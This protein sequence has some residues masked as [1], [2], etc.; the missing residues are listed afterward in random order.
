V[1]RPF[2]TR[3]ACREISARPKE[4]VVTAA[5]TFERLIGAAREGSYPAW[6]EICD[7]L[8]PAVV[9]YLKLRGVV[10]PFS[11]AGD[12]FIELAKE[13]QAYDPASTSFR[14]L[15]FNAARLR[16]E[17][18]QRYS[19]QRFQSLHGVQGPGVSA[20]AD[21]S[22]AFDTL[23][24]EQ[25][26]VLG[27]RI[28]GGLDVEQTASVL[29]LHIDEVEAHES[30]GMTAMEVAL[31]RLGGSVGFGSP[32]ADLDPEPEGSPM[33]FLA[34]LSGDRPSDH[35]ILTCAAR[36]AEEATSLRENSSPSPAEAPVAGVGT[37]LKHRAVA[38]AATMATVMGL[39]GVALAV[40]GATP[41]DWYYGLDT[42]LEA[43]GIGAGGAEERL[44]EAAANRADPTQD[45]GAVTGHLRND[46][47]TATSVDETG[48]Q[49]A[50]AAV[51][52][53]QTGSEQS[54][55]VRD[56]VA[57]FLD[58]LANEEGLSGKE[59]AEIARTLNGKPSKANKPD[60]PGRPENPG[61]PDNPGR[62]STGRP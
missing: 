5:R 12:V 34:A 42:A 51:V 18:E 1:G 6:A 61:R 50:A 24:P 58:Y 8:A 29:N 52:A 43:I 45:S 9:S 26:D 44:L 30:E 3:A 2:N 16:L 23:T 22:K 33:A 53:R 7:E 36:A 27:L 47:T 10:D 11:A 59:I 25:A 4:S 17:V 60:K 32:N 39:S 40:D 54:L 35:F 21:S 55:A 38:L 15:V 14:E 49:R 20:T 57:E 19:R 62:G 28:V 37:R 48:A 31:Q 13:V 46:G 56:R 41:G